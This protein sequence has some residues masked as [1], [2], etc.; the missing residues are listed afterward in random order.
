M[1]VSLQILELHRKNTS[2]EENTLPLN[3]EKPKRGALKRKERFLYNSVDM[4]VAEMQAGNSHVQYPK[5]RLFGKVVSPIANSSTQLDTPSTLESKHVGCAS[6]AQL[7]I[8]VQNMSSAIIDL[9]TNVKLLLATFSEREHPHQFDCELS[10]RQFPLS[11]EEELQ[12]LDTGLQQK[13]TRDRFMAMVTRLM[14]NDHKTSMRYVFSYLMTPEV[15]SGLTNRFCHRL[16]TEKTWRNCT[17]S[18]HKVIFTTSKRNRKQEQI[19]HVIIP[20]I[21][22]PN[23]S[24]I[25]DGNPYRTEKNMS[26]ETN[27]GRKSD[28]DFFLMIHSSPMM[29][30]IN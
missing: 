30:L 18:R 27:H 3:T 12:M 7:Y 15:A 21:G 11:S 14:D 4:D 29:F 1:L 24:H 16:S 17:I 10:I 6:A 23:D 13:E 8:M 9:S 20:D 28:A 2:S 25:F 19:S 26:N 22:F 5:F